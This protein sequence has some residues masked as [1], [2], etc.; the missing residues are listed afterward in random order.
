MKGLRL[1]FI[2]FALA[3]S[4]GLIAGCSK[5]GSSSSGGGGSCW[6]TANP[7]GPG[8]LKVTNNLSTGLQWT[9][10]A[11]A[12]GRGRNPA[13]VPYSAYLREAILSH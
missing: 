13:N 8:Y 4:I 12:F 6:T 9:I 10:R 11:Y 5:G 1:S 3:A 2:V 7:N